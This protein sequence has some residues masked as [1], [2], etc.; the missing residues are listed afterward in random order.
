MNRCTEWRGE[1]AAVFD[2]RVNYI[3]RLARYEDTGLDPEEIDDFVSN[4]KTLIES[5]LTQDLGGQKTCKTCRN[6]CQMIGLNM[7]AC[8]SYKGETE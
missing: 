3:D 6:D 7:P 2:N 5:L 4:V 1:H 8:P